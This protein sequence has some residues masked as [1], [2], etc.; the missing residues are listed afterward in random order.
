[1]QQQNGFSLLEMIGVMAVMAILAGAIA[2][3]VFQMMEDAHETA[4]RQNLDNLA[5]AL[6]QVV[7]NDRRIPSLTT[8]DWTTAIADYASLAPANVLQNEKNQN[9]RLYADPMFFTNTNQAF[10]G[11]TQTS[12]LNTRPYSPRM[13]LVSNLNGS[14][15]A[16]LNSHTR[17]TDVW[18]QTADALIVESDSVIVERINLA[19]EFYEI[20][21]SNSNTGQAGYVLDSGSEAA[22]AAALS[23]VDGSR[24]IFVLA[25][26]RLA[27]RAAPYPGGTT[28]RQILLTDS[29][30]FRY[31]L[32]GGVWVWD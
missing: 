22:I 20:V 13:M 29:Q 18:E 15:S 8:S 10:A 2:P 26:S 9:R 1:M 31:Q 14:V 5:D 4:E 3:A 32:D 21:L 19:S 16:N 25:G 27:L 7:R 23:G 30:N 28:Q 24:T 6:R 11:Y 17:F 12:G